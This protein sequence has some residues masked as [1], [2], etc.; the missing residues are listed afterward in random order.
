[1]KILIVEDQLSIREALVRIIDFY[2]A[3]PFNSD[4]IIARI[5]LI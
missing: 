4:D 2:I 5:N 3:K 1:M